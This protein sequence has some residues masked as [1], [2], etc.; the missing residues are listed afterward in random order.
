MNEVQRMRVRESVGDLRDKSCGVRRR[1]EKGALLESRA[2]APRKERHR[3]PTLSS[4]KAH[5]LE[6]DD[7][8]VAHRTEHVNLT[9]ES[10]LRARVVRPLRTKPLSREPS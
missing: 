9:L 7:I 2:Q 10:V 3:V 1:C 5:A 6:R 4:W 8:R